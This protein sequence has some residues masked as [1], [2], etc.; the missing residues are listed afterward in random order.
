MVA[1]LMEQ[2]VFAQWEEQT[3]TIQLE[4]MEWS[5]QLTTEVLGEVAFSE[6]FGSLDYGIHNSLYHLF[7]F[8]LQEITRH[9]ATVPAVAML[10]DPQRTLD[11]YKHTARLNRTI[12]KI[13]QERVR[14]KQEQQTA[15]TRNKA[16]ETNEKP[17][18][19]LYLLQEDE[20]G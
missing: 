5:A 13:V 6:S 9:L 20:F 17:D 4:A 11:Y 3:G 16:Q 14:R 19:L 8:I 7:V 18:I 12:E 1:E 10:S 15:N 2:K